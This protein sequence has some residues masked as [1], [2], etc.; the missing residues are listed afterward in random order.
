MLKRLLETGFLKAQAANPKHDQWKLAERKARILDREGIFSIAIQI[1]PK[2]EL[3]ETLL[4][5]RKATLVMAAYDGAQDCSLQLES[6]VW[7]LW[8]YYD[9]EIGETELPQSVVS[10]LA[11]AQYLEKGFKKKVEAKRNFVMRMRT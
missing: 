7:L 4:W 11:I 3:N 9:E 8:R 5:L 6:D 1:K 2:I 10:H